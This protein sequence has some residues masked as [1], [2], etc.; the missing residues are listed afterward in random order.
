MR[1]QGVTDKV[2]FALTMCVRAKG[3][4]NTRG[5][6]W[7]HAI[8]LMNAFYAINEELIKVLANNKDAVLSPVV[9]DWYV[10]NKDE[11]SAKLGHARNL[12]THRAKLDTTDHL[13]W[14]VDTWHDTEHPV[15]VAKVTVKATDIQALTGPEFL[16]KV[17]DAFDFLKLGIDDMEREYR[18]RGGTEKL[19]HTEGPQ[20]DFSQL[21]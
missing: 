12:S 5:G 9:R 10:A 2:D 20:A 15:I 18:A 14:Q 3:D 11:M 13:E 6:L 21:F 19:R 17:Q 16:A 8:G 4:C 7:Y 1:L